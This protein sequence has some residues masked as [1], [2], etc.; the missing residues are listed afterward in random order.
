M[1]KASLNITLLSL[2]LSL[3]LLSFAP[4]CGFFSHGLLYLLPQKL[5]LPGFD[6]LSSLPPNSIDV[7]PSRPP[8]QAPSPKNRWYGRDEQN[9]IQ[10]NNLSSHAVWFTRIKMQPPVWFPAQE[11]RRWGQKHFGMSS[12]KK[13]PKENPSFPFCYTN[14]KNADWGEKVWCCIFFTRFCEGEKAQHFTSRFDSKVE[15][16]RCHNRNGAVWYLRASLY[17]GY[18]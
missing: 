15:P 14:G 6:L 2:S 13:K 3:S 7:P 16:H 8:R 17:L 5:I 12:R 18:M 1:W 9:H 11:S 10:V 4:P